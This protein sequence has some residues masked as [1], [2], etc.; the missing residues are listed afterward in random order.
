[1]FFYIL[2]IE[3]KQQLK[4]ISVYLILIF[5]IIFYLTEFIPPNKYYPVKTMDEKHFIY[6]TMIRDYKK[7][8][9]GDDIKPI[10]HGITLN[11]EQK[12]GLKTA[13]LKMNPLWNETDIKDNKANVDISLTDGEFVEIIQG[14]DKA[15]NSKTYYSDEYRSYFFSQYWT[16]HYGLKEENDMRK[17][18]S[19]FKSSLEADIEHEKVMSY[20][21]LGF[22]KYIKINKK[23]SIEVSSLLDRVVRELESEKLTEIKLNR[24]MDEIDAVLGGGT[25][26][27]AKYRKYIFRSYNS[28]SEAK[29]EFADI[30]ENDKVTNAYARY[31]ADYMGMIG[32]VAP[33]FL[34]AFIIL[35]DKKYGMNELI[36]CKSFQSVSYIFA[37]ILGVVIVIMFIF[38]AIAFHATLSFQAN[39]NIYGYIIDK[40]SFFKYITIWVLPTVIF[41]STIGITLSLVFANGIPAILFQ[42]L[43]FFLTAQVQLGDYGFDKV[44]IRYNEVSSYEKFLQYEQMILVNRVYVMALSIFLGILASILYSVR[45]TH[46]TLWHKTFFLNSKI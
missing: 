7:G 30:E 20:N 10:L 45:R 42:I 5:T 4:S 41:S 40:L 2:I 18:V 17:M 11:Q 14:L 28:Y 33:A 6:Y 39:A 16:S 15:I 12:Q 34:S 1:M 13:I 24:L 21:F 32:L 38:Y 31:L 43:L 3:L 26:Y 19:S 27:G 23:Q 25:N 29:K 22:G 9:T 35:R 44:I 46:G 8:K 36:Y 37:K